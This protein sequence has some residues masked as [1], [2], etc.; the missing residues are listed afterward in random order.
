MELASRHPLAI[1]RGRDSLSPPPEDLRVVDVGGHG[2]NVDVA[3]ALHQHIDNRLLQHT[4]VPRH[5]TTLG[6]HTPHAPAPRI[7]QHTL[8]MMD[9]VKRDSVQ[10]E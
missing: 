4:P 10:R 5:H 6:C 3:F 8:T 1:V 9:Y 2:D 7:L